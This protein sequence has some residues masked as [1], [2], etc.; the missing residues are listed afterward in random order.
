MNTNLMKEEE[1]PRNREE[2]P[3]GANL[4]YVTWSKGQERK[5]RPICDTGYCLEVGLGWG[6]DGKGLGE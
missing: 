3:N 5:L 4:G 2:G 6:T 1:K